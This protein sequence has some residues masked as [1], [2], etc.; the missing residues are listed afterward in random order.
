[1]SGPVDTARA[2]WGPD[3]PDWVLALARACAETSQNKVA[4]QIGRSAAL[5]STVLRRQY[6]GDLVA[7]EELVRAHLLAETV[8][9]PAL[10][11]LPLHECRDWRAKARD[12]A[13]TNSLRVRMW[14]ACRACP[15][16]TGGD[17]PPRHPATTIGE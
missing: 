16:F 12:F 3:L 7:V 1:M 10:G 8:R 5:V 17:V 4:G 11:T 15:R 9:C 14:R 6:P 2:H 13:N